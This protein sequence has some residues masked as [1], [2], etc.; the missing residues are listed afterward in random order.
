MN[1]TVDQV[2]VFGQRD[3]GHDYVRRPSVYTLLHDAA[4]NVAVV[5][6]PRGCYLPGGGAEKG[7]TPQQTVERETREECGFVLRVH[8][9][10]GS[11]IQFCYSEDERAYFEKICDFLSAEIVGVTT[12]TESDHEV[13]WVTPDQAC[14]MLLHESHRWAVQRF[15]SGGKTPDS[16]AKVRLVGL[17]ES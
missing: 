4:G 8:S 11:A 12:P 6:T 1:S 5:R 14:S 2:P 3:P 17:E 10:L 16:S 9:R 7:E 15:F 13:L